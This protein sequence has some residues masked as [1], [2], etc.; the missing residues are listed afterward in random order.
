[1][2]WRTYVGCDLVLNVTLEA[3]HL[4]AFLWIGYNTVQLIFWVRPHRTNL[5]HLNTQH[6]DL[7]LSQLCSVCCK[8]NSFQVSKDAKYN[9]PSEYNILKLQWCARLIMASRLYKCVHVFRDNLHKLEA[10]LFLLKSAY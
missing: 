3:V 9:A 1:M 6:K 8:Q 2:F 7:G 4:R 10:Y 5:S